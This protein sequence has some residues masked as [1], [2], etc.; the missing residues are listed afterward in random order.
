VGINILS[1]FDGHSTGR[2]V[3]QRAG[4]E[5]DK[6]FASEIDENAIQISKNNFDD[7]IRLGDI[8]KIDKEIIMKLPK[9]DLLI[10]GSPCQGFSRNGACLNFEDDRSKLFFEYVRILNIIREYNNPKVQF[11][12]ENVEM[13]KEWR[14]VISDYLK[15]EY[16][17]I[18]SK[19][20]SAQNRPRLY[21]TSTYIEPPEDKQIKLLDI[22]ENVDTSNYIEYKGLK[23]DP[24]ISE[25]AYSLID[26]VNSEVRINQ[27]TKQGYIVAENGDGVNLQFPTSKTRRGRVIKEKSNTLDCSCDICVYYDEIIRKFTIT[28]LERLQTLPDGY[29]KGLNDKARI[30]AI[31]N[32]WTADAVVDILKQYKFK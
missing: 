27:A 14:D 23:I 20:V 10:G 28:E 21:W 24:N 9:I 11:L 31:G 22:I 4:I 25:K 18:N 2:L 15:C 5:V 26:V 13:K 17:L 29:T 12:L 19:L 30:K 6:Y 8:T 3:C 7:I 32:G 16:T 1:L